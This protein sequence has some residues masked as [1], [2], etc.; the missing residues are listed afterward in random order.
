MIPRNGNFSTFSVE[1]SYFSL[2]YI[3]FTLLKI[4][5]NFKITVKVMCAYSAGVDFGL[6]LWGCHNT[7]NIEC[8]YQFETP[9]KI[10]IEYGKH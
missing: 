9:N 8:E 1:T 6:A 4:T 5:A 7:N 3:I 2:V 10:T